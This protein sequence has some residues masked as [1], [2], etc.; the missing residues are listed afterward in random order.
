MPNQETNQDQGFQHCVPAFQLNENEERFE[1]W[2]LGYANCEI[3]VATQHRDKEGDGLDLG[4]ER[5]SS[6]LAHKKINKQNGAA[7]EK[8]ETD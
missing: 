6:M 7:Q 4:V 2:C 3:T 1:Q 8:L 5:R